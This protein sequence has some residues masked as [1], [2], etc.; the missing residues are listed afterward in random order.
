M[1]NIDG[2]PPISQID[3]PSKQNLY[4]R[5][6]L[7]RSRQRHV[8]A[9][10]GQPSSHETKVNCSSLF[11]NFCQKRFD[12]R[13][14][15]EILFKLCEK[16]FFS[17]PILDMIQHQIV[18]RTVVLCSATSLLLKVYPLKHLHTL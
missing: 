12:K 17:Q 5:R 9:I 4:I 13:M 15:E 14:A 8:R 16:V 18:N 6:H 11:V 10:A 3:Y 2:I 1:R 7:P